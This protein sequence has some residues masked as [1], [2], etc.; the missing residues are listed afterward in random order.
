MVK[1]DDEGENEI[2]GNSFCFV[3]N[4]IHG[5]LAGGMEPRRPH[6]AR[7]LKYACWNLKRVLMLSSTGNLLLASR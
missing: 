7:M 4:M 3:G 1:V 5:G 6:S 2:P